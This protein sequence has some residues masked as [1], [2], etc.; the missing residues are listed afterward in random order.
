MEINNCLLVLIIGILIGA[1]GTLLINRRTAFLLREQIHNRDVEL[2]ELSGLETE[3]ENKV[4]DQ[5]KDFE[6]KMVLVNETKDLMKAEFQNLASTIMEEKSKTFTLQ[7][8]EN[9]KIILDPL[10]EQIGEFKKKVEDVYDKEAQGRASLFNEITN[11]KSLNLKISEDAINL[12]RAL[13][14]DS[15]TQGDWGQVVLERILEMSG[16]EKG[17]EYELQVRFA[18]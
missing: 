1:G 8:K 4:R 12:T 11:L 13:K 9:I 6:A 7:N 5:Q 15:K 18:R 10:R 17:R 14:G 2:A 3:M 16:L